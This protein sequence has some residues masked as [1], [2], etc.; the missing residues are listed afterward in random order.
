[1]KPFDNE[2]PLKLKKLSKNLSEKSF[3]GERNK[4]EKKSKKQKK[5]IR[6]TKDL[7]EFL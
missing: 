5:I 2:K 3:F 4:K 7:K 6:T 1:M